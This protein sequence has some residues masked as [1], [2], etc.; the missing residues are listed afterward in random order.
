M[1]YWR[2]RFLTP[3]G[4]ALA[5]AVTGAA[6]LDAQ[7]IRGTVS[8]S[9]D[10]RPLE[11]ANVV[12]VGTMLR[13]VTG[14]DGS[15]VIRGAPAGQTVTVRA[16][17]IG[18]AP[19]TREVS[20]PANGEVVANFVLAVRPVQLD[21]VV[22]LGY[23]TASRASV[24][25]AVTSIGGEQV[26]GEPVAGID[27]ALLGKAAG[28][29][30]IQN[31]GTPGNGITIRIRGSASLSASNQPLYV[32][33]GVPITSETIGQLDFGGQEITGVAGLAIADIER[34]DILKDA[35]A[36]AIYGSRGSN[37]VVLITTK[38]GSGSPS[39]TLNAS[40]G[41]QKV[42]RRVDLLNATEYLIYMNE[43]AER[44]GYG[45]DYYGVVG[46]D[47][48]VSTDWQDAIFRT[49]PIRDIV[50]AASGGT[51]FL[52]YRV[53]GSYFDQV[54]T[55][56]GSGYRK[57]SSRINLDFN[58]GQRLT[59]AGGLSVTGEDNARI[60]SDDAVLGTIPNG[61]ASPPTVPVRLAD[62]S[63]STIDDGLIYPNAVAIGEYNTANARSN[64]VLGTFE[65]RAQLLSTLTLSGRVGID[66][67]R[68]HETRFASQKVAGSDAERGNGIATDAFSADNKYVF[69]AMLAYQGQTGKHSL[70]MTGGASA[71]LNRSSW[72]Y[73]RGEGMG[74]ERFNQVQN[75]AIITGW[76][77]AYQENNMLAGFGR[78]NYSWADRYLLSAS[79]RY[80]GSSRFGPSTKWGFF[81]AV[82]LAWIVS[83]EAFLK[84]WK[85]LDQL[86]LRGSYGL[87]GNQASQYYPWQGVVCTTNYGPV[88]GLSPC[89]LSNEDLKW[90]RTAQLNLGADFTFWTGRMTFSADWYR[91]QTND[92]L[93]NRPVTTTSGQSSI[94]SNVGNVLN[95]GVEFQL[96]A[97]PFYSRTGLNWTT[98]LN[99]SHNKNKVTALYND[100]PFSDGWSDANRVEV[101]LPIGAFHLFKF[102]GVDPQT[103]DA[104]YRT[105]DGGVTTDPTNEDRVIVGSPWP[106]WTGGI[107]NA[108]AWKQFDLSFLFQ[109]SVGAKIYNAMRLYANDGGY[110]ADNK[111]RFAWN[112]WQQPGDI[113]DEPRASA[114]G[115]SGARLPSSRFIEDADYLRLLD[116]TFGYQLPS[117][118]ARSL[119]MSNARIYVS[120][121]NL[122]TVTPYSGYFPDANSTGASSN[123]SLG[124]DFYTYPL[125]R[126]F[127]FGVQA[128]W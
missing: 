80:D 63:Y 72:N 73:V 11:G 69:D 4:L 51:D 50:L 26:L 39:I 32:I 33:D 102:E 113:T 61:L 86:K 56:L 87:T 43:G 95:T 21:E 24:T 17:R 118:M 34:I 52:R 47:D 77:G 10:Q 99:L 70:G 126:S 119:G 94:F 120:G 1:E 78:V 106:T 38:R 3:I 116:L 109:F 40:I 23:G 29:H 59:F 20:V 82:S 111:F 46:V 84:D 41:T 36:A 122:I 9:T 91:K 83:E 75:A 103:G 13:S 114:D 100:E 105:A 76:D 19:V 28:V 101:G 124:T 90:E 31:A 8:D 62:G 108:L 65:A 66:F 60:V 22:S 125:A 74:D 55:T 25:A 112:R 98:T 53:S 117:G 81:P 49:A 88:S 42:T 71:E 96:T 48:V 5:C 79:F 64:R 12:I 104:L 35:A 45:P 97:Q 14:T 7:S 92:L 44:D 85:A 16:Q 58:K 67:L 2:C 57:L 89:S 6:G 107:T 127:R 27:A 110:Y 93:V 123:V 121:H 128:G 18:Y 115:L 37:G 15:Y 54:G 30:V 68:L